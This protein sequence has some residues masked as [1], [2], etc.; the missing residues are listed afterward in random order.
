MVRKEVVKLHTSNTFFLLNML[1]WR[2]TSFGL[3]KAKLNCL[4]MCRQSS[5]FPNIKL[6]AG[7]L[8]HIGNTF[9]HTVFN[10]PVSESLMV[11]RK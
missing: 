10:V 1:F 2:F 5:V 6:N 4:C 9:R 7:I 3:Y 11:L 8:Y